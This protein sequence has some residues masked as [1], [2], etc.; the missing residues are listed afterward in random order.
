M[1]LHI[2]AVK[3]NPMLKNKKP[4]GFAVGTEMMTKALLVPLGLE[5]LA[6][7]LP[8]LKRFASE[9]ICQ[10]YRESA[11]EKTEWKQATI[12][13]EFSF[14]CVKGFAAKYLTNTWIK[15]NKQ[16]AI[17]H[18]NSS[19]NFCDF[20]FSAVKDV[21]KPQKDSYLMSVNHTE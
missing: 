16:K 10:W 8:R 12:P 4:Q 11:S 2:S 9:L 13:G 19:L 3:W 20:L 7:I 5:K 15:H 18:S 21:W 17:I 14:S 6:F 1:Q